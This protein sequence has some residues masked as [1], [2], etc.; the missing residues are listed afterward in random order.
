MTTQPN[1]GPAELRRLKQIL[2][3]DYLESEGI[4][5]DAQVAAWEA[6][7]ARAARAE[8]ALERA[9]TL[10]GKLR[11]GL[12]DYWITLHPEVA[13]ELA[14]AL[15][16]DGATAVPAAPTCDLCKIQAGIQAAMDIIEPLP[17]IGR[18]YDEMVTRAFDAL[19]DAYGYHRHEHYAPDDDRLKVVKSAPD[20]AR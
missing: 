3:S 13:D 8:V 18:H 14:A 20:G 6:D 12:D 7:I 9:R 2:D 5:L 17:N 1:T 15:A 11:D 4:S 16:L 10:V 19:D